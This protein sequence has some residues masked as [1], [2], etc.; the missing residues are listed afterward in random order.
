MNR[1]P[2][3]R[4]AIEVYCRKLADA[5]NN[6]GYTVNDQVVLRLPVSWT[7]ENIK[8]LMFK[9]IMTALYPEKESTT[10]LDTDEVSEVYENLNL[11]VSERTG[12]SVAWPCEEELMQE[13]L[14][15][16]KTK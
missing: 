4:K 3:Q 10:Q 1:T 6:A 9:Q 5:L 7:Q 11:A 8:E 12:V 16:T 2:Q 15:R 14:G 13:R